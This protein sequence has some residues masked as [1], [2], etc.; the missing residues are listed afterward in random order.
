MSKKLDNAAQMNEV[1]QKAGR[2]YERNPDTG[3]LRSREIGDHGNERIEAHPTQDETIAFNRKQYLESEIA[4]AGHH[5]GYVM[6]GLKN[7]L[8]DKKQ[9]RLPFIKK[10]MDSMH[11]DIQG[12]VRREVLNELW[13]SN[14]ITYNGKWYVQL[15]EVVN[16][17]GDHNEE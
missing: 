1:E 6:E 15:S 5:D 10:K 12:K 8:E 9:V 17:I 4:A 11:Y 16:I 3:E 2:I 13:A 7:E 14:K